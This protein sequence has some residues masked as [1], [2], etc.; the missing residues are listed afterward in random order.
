MLQYPICRKQYQFLVKEI[1]PTLH[2]HLAFCSLQSSTIGS[3]A[4]TLGKPVLRKHS[5]NPSQLLQFS[6]APLAS[7]TLLMRQ[8]GD[9]AI[10]QPL[11]FVSNMLA[12]LPPAGLLAHVQKVYATS[13]FPTDTPCLMP[14]MTHSKSC[15]VICE[16]C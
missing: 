9:I 13:Y 3:L 14:I 16:S 10:G 6:V 8:F 15:E 12:C 1:Y 2:F 5:V 7:P 11:S 4:S